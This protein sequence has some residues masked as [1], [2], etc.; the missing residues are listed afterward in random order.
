MSYSIGHDALNLIPRERMARV[1][2]NDNWEIVRHVTGKDP[3]KDPDAG[4]QFNDWAKMDFCWV[5]NDGPVG[6]GKRGRVTDMGHAEYM[7]DGSDFRAPVAS[8]FAS[9]ADVLAFDAVAEYGLTPMDELV[10]FYEAFHQETKRRNPEQ[11]VTGGYYNTVVSGAI[12]IFGWDRL[13]EAAGDD[14][15]TFGDKVLGSIF[16]Q[17]M[18]H[19]KAWAQTSI[20]YYMC[21]DDMVWTSGAFMRP[22]FY[23]TYIFPRYKELWKML[24]DAGKKVLYTADGLYD[25]FMDDIVEA[26]A[27]GLIFEPCNDLEMIVNKYGQT[28]SLFGGVDCRVL[29]FKSIPE[30]EEEVRK[31]AALAMKC[32]GF[33]FGC[34]NHFP[35]NIPLEN[36]L[37]YFKFLD[38]YCQRPG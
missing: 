1:E 29:T 9:S 31:K 5:V 2:Y 26:G 30:I 6:W 20:E 24:H 28:H 14:P 19:A 12:Q 21:H 27:D 33:F 13:L 18:H 10:A 4:R 3:R 17:T 8:P 11:V 15:D 16:E 38:K 35:A 23:R 25:F 37:A 32:P 36:A 7:E 34:G 22:S